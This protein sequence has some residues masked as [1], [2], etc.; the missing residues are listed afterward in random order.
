[1]SDEGG[2][3]SRI[4]LG[5]STIGS[6]GGGEDSRRMATGEGVESESTERRASG[7][8]MGTGDVR[9]EDKGLKG[10]L[11]SDSFAWTGEEEEGGESFWTVTFKKKG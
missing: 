7:A 1:M 8:V 6:G 4:N 9:G 10:D 3:G 11:G 2:G 5:A